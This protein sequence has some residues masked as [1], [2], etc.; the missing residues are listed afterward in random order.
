MSVWPGW[1]RRKLNPFTANGLCTKN[2]MCSSNRHASDTT[3]CVEFYFF[4]TRNMYMCI[5][6]YL[7]WLF[8]ICCLLRIG[9]WVSS[10]DIL[11]AVYPE[12]EDVDLTQT[13][14]IVYPMSHRL[15]VLCVLFFTTSYFWACFCV[16]GKFFFEKKKKKFTRSNF[17]CQRNQSTVQESQADGVFH[18]ILRPDKLISNKISSVTL[19]LPNTHAHTCYETTILFAVV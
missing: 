1:T 8:V 2:K 10:T 11:P 9:P 13:T 14:G 18:A 16:C 4:F 7:L 3:N 19:L 5:V 15:R 12:L 6:V 17:I